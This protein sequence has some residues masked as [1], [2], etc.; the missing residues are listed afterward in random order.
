VIA[1]DSSDNNG[2]FERTNHARSGW[3]MFQAKRVKI[4][5]AIR[6]T[7]NLLAVESNLIIV[8]VS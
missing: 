8:A 1:L 6:E 5:R 7:E 3:I 4:T 2:G